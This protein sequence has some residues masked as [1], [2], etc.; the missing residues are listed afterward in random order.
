M[1][2][3]S[4][5]TLEQQDEQIIE[6]GDNIKHAMGHRVN[7]GDIQLSLQGYRYAADKKREEGHA[8][9]ILDKCIELVKHDPEDKKQWVWYA[10][11]TIQDIKDGNETYGVSEQSYLKYEFKEGRKV[12]TEYDEF[13]RTKAI[14]KAR[15]NAIRDQLPL[16]F[17]QSIINEFAE[18]IKDIKVGQSSTT[19]STVQVPTEKQLQYLKKLGYTGEPP[20]TTKEASDLIQRYRKQ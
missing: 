17:I 20:K 18:E 6:L 4:F 2:Q 1:S 11:I 15:R 14:S 7:G 13:G 3:T 5:N 19:S 9:K 16:T 8:F 10:E 12:L